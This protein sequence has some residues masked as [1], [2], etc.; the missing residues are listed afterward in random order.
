MRVSV[1]FLSLC[2]VMNTHVERPLCTHE[3]TSVTCMYTHTCNSCGKLWS[4]ELLSEDVLLSSLAIITENNGMSTLLSHLAQLACWA[5]EKTEAPK[6][7]GL[8][9]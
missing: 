5:D 6:A 2:V 4:R 8:C 9:S 1:L 3:Q 7:H